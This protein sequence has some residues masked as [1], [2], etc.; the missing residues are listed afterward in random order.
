MRFL[1]F[2]NPHV[3]VAHGVAVVLEPD[4]SGRSTFLLTGSGLV[5][6]RIIIVDQDAV[7]LGG[8]AGRG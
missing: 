1:L 7:K 6:E 3:A 8:D 2:L 5:L 4:G